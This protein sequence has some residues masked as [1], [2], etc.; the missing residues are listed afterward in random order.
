MKGYYATNELE[1]LER[2]KTGEL[3]EGDEVR[4]CRDVA[5]KGIPDTNGMVGEVVNVWASCEVDPACCCNELA[6][7]APITVHLRPAHGSSDTAW[8]GYYAEDELQVVR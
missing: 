8:I 4:V 5:A 2:G 3:V 7:D 1:R 6:I